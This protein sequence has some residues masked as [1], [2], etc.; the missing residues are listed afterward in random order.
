MTR[1]FILLAAAMLA[2]CSGTFSGLL[3]HHVAVTMDDSKCLAASRWGSIAITGDIAAS[4]CEA[5]VAGR[6]ALEVLRMLQS[7]RPA[8]AAPAAGSKT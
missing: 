7:A 1:I 5:I 6:R 8:P 3:T 2:G 4:E